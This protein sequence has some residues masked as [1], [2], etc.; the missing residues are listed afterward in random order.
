MSIDDYIMEFIESCPQ[1]TSSGYLA[2]HQLLDQITELRSDILIP[3]YCHC[4][5]SEPRINAWIGPNGT[6]S[7][8]HQDPE[9]N[10]FAQ[11]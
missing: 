7:P 5:T 2:Q 11:V 6:V 3:D 10:I 1:S 4:G 8:A 9:H